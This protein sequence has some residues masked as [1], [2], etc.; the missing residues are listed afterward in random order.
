[1][2][3]G[4]LGDRIV[5]GLAVNDTQRMLAGAIPAAL[6][7]LAVQAALAGLQRWLVPAPLRGVAQRPGAA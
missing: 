2:G 6:L 1:V 5:A 4:G 7:A 3:A